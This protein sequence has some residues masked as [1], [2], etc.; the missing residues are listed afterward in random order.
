[1]KSET[2]TFLV[3]LFLAG[4]LVAQESAS[5]Y[6]IVLDQTPAGRSYKLAA[7]ALAKLRAPVLLVP[8]TEG[9][10]GKVFDQ[11]RTLKPE[12]V[13]FVVPPERLEDN[14][15]G[16]VFERASRLNDDP[17]L[18]FAY[19]FITGGTPEDALALV[20]NTARAESDRGS[21]AKKFVA[22]G[23]TFRESDLGPFAYQQAMLH[24][25]YGYRSEPINPIDESVDWQTRVPWE[26]RKLDG[27][28]LVYWAGHGMGDRLCGIDADA[29]TGFHLDHAVVVLGPCHSAV[30][31]L[32]HDNQP[33][34][35]GVKTVTIPLERSICLKLIKAGAVAQL[36]S[37]ASSSWG[38]VGPAITGFFNEAKTMGKA[39]LDR[40]N[41]HIRQRGIGRFSVLPF[42]NGQPS[43]QFLRDER[44]P[45][46]I[47]SIARVL[48][49]GDPAY[50]PF[51]D[52]RAVVPLPDVAERP[53]PMNPASLTNA[54]PPFMTKARVDLSQATVTELI[55]ALPNDT[56]QS[57]FAVLNEVIRRGPPAVPSL[58]EA[59]KKSEAWLVP[60]AL[61]AIKDA[62]AV[63]PLIDVLAQRRWSP[64][65]EIVVE[66][67]ESVT[68][69]KLGDDAE[70]WKTWSE[71]NRPTDH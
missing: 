48:L 50:R 29:F 46:E 2:L 38:N 36:G 11:L 44:N 18:D 57:G 12:C 70:V 20:H 52:K 47:Q 54:T 71:K 6:V 5:S 34:S 27:A 9:G 67:L 63:S 1:M 30:T 28:S 23:H 22:V 19:G 31:V 61:G 66:A 7:D 68:G 35:L 32:R 45:G 16:E 62:R 8:L 3:G 17:Y 58:L 26:M 42:E 59:L 65:K 53:H 51:P 15:V 41:A 69:T 21:I 14:F 39:L 13:A 64:Y 4:T 55:Q 49:I 25:R 56:P 10:L 43:P 60:K 37:T 24:E 40:L 33:G